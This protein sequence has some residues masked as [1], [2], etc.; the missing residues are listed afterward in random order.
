[1]QRLSN[2]QSETKK[3][4][5][6]RPILESASVISHFAI[7]YCRDNDKL[8]R[9][10]TPPPCGPDSGQAY[11]TARGAGHLVAVAESLV[12]VLVEV[13]GEVTAQHVRTDGH[14]DEHRLLSA[15]LVLWR[16]QPRRQRTPEKPAQTRSSDIIVCDHTELLVIWYPFGKIRLL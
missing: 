16:A 1:M 3:S 10:S 4:S 9:Q 8:E 14:H 15:D 12:V 13:P 7:G 6:A 11:A 5:P 2:Y